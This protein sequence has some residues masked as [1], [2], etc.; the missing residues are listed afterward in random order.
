MTRYAFNEGTIVELNNAAKHS[1]H[2][3]TA[4]HRI[5]LIFDYVDATHVIQNR[6]TLPAGQ[7]CRQ[8]RGRVE[9]V[10]KVDARAEEQAKKQ[11][12]RMLIEIESI[13]KD[14]R[15]ADAAAALTMACRHYFI[16]QINA[17]AFVKAIESKV[18]AGDKVDAGFREL[19]WKKLMEMF[20]L[21]DVRM[22]DELAQARI[23]KVFAPNWVVIGAQ[24][25]GT[26]SLYDYLS[27]HP[28]AMKGQRREPHFFDW[29]WDAAFKHTLSVE[30]R[31][32]YEPVLQ[33]FSSG[34][35]DQ[36]LPVDIALH[37]NSLDDLRFVVSL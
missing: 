12:G 34:G 33:S 24:K 25:C 14:Q 1:V 29:A 21:V 6:T 32:K 11:A 36:D 7:M 35:S 10:D 23:K 9:L 16:E 22:G 17:K 18:L 2:N 28:L 4:H 31:A 13:V 15:D 5:H 8:V 19:V 27:Q 37:G 20:T 26:T 3:P 30:D